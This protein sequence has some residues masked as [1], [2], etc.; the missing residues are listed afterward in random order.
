MSWQSRP[1]G[2]GG[3]SASQWP[4]QAAVVARVSWPAAISAGVSSAMSS[5]RGKAVGGGSEYWLVAIPATT[6]PA[7]TRGRLANRCPTPGAD[8][9][10]R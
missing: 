6:E 10:G 5:P 4:G 9:V 1:S 3:Y 2:W 7:C 8:D